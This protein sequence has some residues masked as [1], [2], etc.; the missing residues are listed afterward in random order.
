MPNFYRPWENFQF[1]LLHLKG[2]SFLPKCL[3]SLLLK[4]VAYAEDTTKYPKSEIHQQGIIC[5]K[6]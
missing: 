2:N 4:Y 6:I 1:I 5:T 3:Q